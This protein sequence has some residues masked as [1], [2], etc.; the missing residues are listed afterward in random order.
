MRPGSL[1]LSLLNGILNLLTLIVLPLAFGVHRG[2][3]CLD[4]EWL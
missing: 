2:K 3:S 4:S 1:V